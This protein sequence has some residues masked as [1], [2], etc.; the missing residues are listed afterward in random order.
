VVR[1]SVISRHPGRVV[2]DAGRRVLGMDYGPPIPGGFAG[3]VVAVSDE[4]TTVEM[5]DPL[6]ALGELLDLVP[7]QIRTTFNLHDRVWV[8]RRGRNVEA[9][10]VTARGRSW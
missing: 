2:L 10:P 1:A 8:S 9:W 3:R 7:G 5:A 4:H 6:P